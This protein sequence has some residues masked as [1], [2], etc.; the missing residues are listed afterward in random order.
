ME[1]FQLSCARQIGFMKMHLPCSMKCRD[2]ELLAFAVLKLSVV[3]CVVSAA[4]CGAGLFEV[5]CCESSTVRG[6]RIPCG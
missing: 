5:V 6:W 4:R 2:L 1:V 3:K